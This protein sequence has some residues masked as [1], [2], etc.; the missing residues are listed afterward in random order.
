MTP[1]YKSG[2]QWDKISAVQKKSLIGI[3]VRDFGIK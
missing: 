3:P 1:V 2:D